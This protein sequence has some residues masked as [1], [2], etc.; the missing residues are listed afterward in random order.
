MYGNGLQIRILSAT[1]EKNHTQFHYHFYKCQEYF[2]VVDSRENIEGH[3]IFCSR[4]TLSK[5]TIALRVKMCFVEKR[6][7]T[8]E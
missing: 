5:Y 2:N 3:A 4:V 1:T 6:I 7:L 8:F